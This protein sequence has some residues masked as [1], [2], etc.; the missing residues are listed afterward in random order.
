MRDL[1]ELMRDTAGKGPEGGL[2]L[3]AVLGEGRRRV[4]RRRT[5]GAAGTGV[6]VLAL[7]VGSLA[8]SR[9]GVGLG[10]R[11]APAGGTEPVGPVLTFADAQPATE[12]ED[13]TVLSSYNNENLDRDNG[14]Y[15]QGITPDGRVVVED[16]PHLE[17]GMYRLGLLDPETGRTAWLGAPRSARNGTDPNGLVG[18]SARWLVWQLT[19]QRGGRSFLTIDR[20]NGTQG[21]ME[22][23]GRELGLERSGMPAGGR[24]VL[25]ADDRIYFT[26]PSQAPD[27]GQL[28]S[29]PVDDVSGL[30]HEGTVG[31]FDV[32]GDLLTYTEHTNRPSSI[33]HVRDLRTGEE[34]GFD[35]RSG[36]T[37]NSLGLA[38]EGDVIALQ[39]Y[40]GTADGVRDDRLQLVTGSGEPIVTFRDSGLEGGAL[41]DRHVTLVG[42]GGKTAG[43]YV[44]DLGSGDLVRVSK[45]QVKF[46]PTLLGE[47]DLLTWATP[48]NRRHGMRLWVA[49]FG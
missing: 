39:Q 35:A 3:D 1:Q 43:A 30:R 4:R 18:A 20:A 44:Y 33:V 37:C 7:I 16:G 21:T 27:T 36:S 29:V 17:D 15:F 2:D 28:W 24:A 23:S 31:D 12:G 13:Y 26:A 41:T 14:R 46:D 49:R 45:D 8:V 34:Q 40:C 22:I 48:V 10:D 19:S 25:G 32:D 38:R 11:I 47:R 5:A 42:Y 6:A 9:L